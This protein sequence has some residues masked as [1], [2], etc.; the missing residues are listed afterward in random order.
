MDLG[1]KGIG[2]KGWSNYNS[3]D[4]EEGQLTKVISF[5]TPL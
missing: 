3:R 5:L 1:M 2:G 4:E